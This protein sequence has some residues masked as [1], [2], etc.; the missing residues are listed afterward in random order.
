[1]G[2]LRPLPQHFSKFLFHSVKSLGG[3]EVQSYT[4]CL[5]RA[6]LCLTA[7]GAAGCELSVSSITPLTDALQCP[8]T[9]FLGAQSSCTHWEQDWWDFK[10]LQQVRAI[11]ACA[12]RKHPG[13]IHLYHFLHLPASREGNT[14]SFKSKTSWICIQADEPTPRRMRGYEAI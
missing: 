8:E 14:S 12:L 1:M 5:W 10:D 11:S 2:S 7:V 3:L 6:T 4:R 13:I 9:G